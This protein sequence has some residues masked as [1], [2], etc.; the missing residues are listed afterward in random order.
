MEQT[1][2]HPVAHPS[3]VLHSSG[4]F[5]HSPTAQLTQNEVELLKSYVNTYRTSKNIDWSKVS[6]EWNCAVSQQQSGIYERNMRRLQT[7][8]KNILQTS[9]AKAKRASTLSSNTACPTNGSSSSSSSSSTSSSSS[10][11]KINR[12]L[13]STGQLSQLPWN[14]HG[15][16]SMRSVLGGTMAASVALGS[17][18]MTRRE[19][20]S[21]DLTT[22]EHAIV[23]KVAEDRLRQSLPMCREAVMKEYHHQFPN[24]TRDQG[25]LMAYWKSYKEGATYRGLVAQIAKEKQ[26][27][28]S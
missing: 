19:E 28:K 2:T 15:G 22:A 25:K 21:G 10:S 6:T 13:Q 4:A 23:K 5:D 7:A 14:T 8:W 16:I 26:Q 3:V 18:P 20:R 24:H 12:P 1:K 9:S 17:H 11:G 27:H